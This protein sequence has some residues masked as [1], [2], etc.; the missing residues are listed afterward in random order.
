MTAL[1][2]PKKESYEDET[3]VPLRDLT[4]AAPDEGKEGRVTRAVSVD[5]MKFRCVIRSVWLRGENLM[6]SR[7]AAVIRSNSM[8]S[9]NGGMST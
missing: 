3:L 9:Q 8:R 4:V 7:S 2:H 6:L 1:L 5:P